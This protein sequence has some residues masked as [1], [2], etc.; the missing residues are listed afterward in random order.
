MDVKSCISQLLEQLTKQQATW[1][2]HKYTS[3]IVNQSANDAG[4]KRMQCPLKLPA[5]LFQNFDQ[6]DF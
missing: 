6:I 3:Y 2:E 1:K 4:G 5:F